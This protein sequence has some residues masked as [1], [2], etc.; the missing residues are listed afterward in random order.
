MLI[1]MKYFIL[2]LVLYFFYLIF[3]ELDRY[4]CLIYYYFLRMI[5]TNKTITKNM[6][7]QTLRYY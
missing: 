3:L 7:S 2:S 1:Y 4:F 5:V 6:I